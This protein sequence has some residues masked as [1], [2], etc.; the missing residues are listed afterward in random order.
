M[1]GTTNSMFFVDEI[2]YTHVPCLEELLLSL[3]GC[4]NPGDNIHVTG[5]CERDISG[6]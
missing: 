4:Q 6:A 5:Y 2:L 1:A 3:L